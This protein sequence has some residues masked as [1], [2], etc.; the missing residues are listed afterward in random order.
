[1][2]KEKSRDL[3]SW[4]LFIFGLL[5]MAYQQWSGRIDIVLLLIYTLMIGVPDI[6]SMISL[7]KT[8]PIVIQERE[9]KS[10]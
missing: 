3:R 4:I 8:S 7:V 9:Q 1:M 2:D 6:V 5:G 10:K